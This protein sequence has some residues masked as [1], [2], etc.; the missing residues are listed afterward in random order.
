MRDTQHN[1]ASGHSEL[2]ETV[3]AGTATDP[4]AING[5]GRL[6]SVSVHPG[7]GGA[8]LVEYTTSPRA[9]V[10]A[11]TARWIAWPHGEVDTDTS[12]ALLGPVTALRCTATTA[13]AVWE[14]LA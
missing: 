8:A 6:P 11:G 3:T 13:D 14:V 7:A 9:D 5:S 10:E 12:D 2:S 1:P 4:V